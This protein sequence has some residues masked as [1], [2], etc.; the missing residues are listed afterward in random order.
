MGGDWVVYAVFEKLTNVIPGDQPKPE[1]YKTVTFDLDGKGTTD[2]LT[3]C[4]VDPTVVVTLEAPSVVANTGLKHTGWNKLLIGKF[5]KKYNY[6]GYRS[7]NERPY[8]GGY[9]A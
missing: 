6:K 7:E 3:T 1:G 5:G 8:K 9:T 2:D 4:Y